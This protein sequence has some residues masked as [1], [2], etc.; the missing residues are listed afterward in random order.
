MRAILKAFGEEVRK[1]HVHC[2][3]S[4]LALEQFASNE[5]IQC[6]ETYEYA[7]ALGNMTICLHN[8]QVTAFYLKILRFIL[9]GEC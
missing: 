4:N 7:L 1:K 6:T 5:A 2:I 3:F 9:L 8:F